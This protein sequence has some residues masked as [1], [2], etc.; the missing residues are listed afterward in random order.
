MIL[1]DEEIQNAVK[2]GVIEISDFSEDCLQPAS[3]DLRIGEEG[4]TLSVGTIIDIN[5]EGELQIQPGDFALIITHEK[6]RLPANMLG[7]FG[8]R[9]EYARMGFLA[10]AGPQVDP[11]FEGKLVIG[12]V[13]FSS[14]SI[15]LPY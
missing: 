5:K 13:N 14:N 6:L 2:N 4:Y 15:K 10:T 9:S 12:I 7:R 1:V 3:Y 11:G 8:L